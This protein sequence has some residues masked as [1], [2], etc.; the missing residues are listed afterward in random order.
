[1]TNLERNANLTDSTFRWKPDRLHH[2]KEAIGVTVS[3]FE[4]VLRTFAD[5]ASGLDVSKGIV[6]VQIRDEIVEASLEESPGQV[7]V[8]EDGDKVPAAMWITRRIARIPLL[9]DRI[10][11]H[12][13]DEPHYVGPSGQIRDRINAAPDGADKNV[14]EVDAAVLKHLKGT[15]GTTTVHYLTSDAGEGK[16]TVIN[17]MARVQA[18]RFKRKEADWLLLPIRLGGRAF[19]SFDDIVVAE[20]AN[21]LRFQFFY[22][23]AF[24]ELVKMRVIVPAFD[25]FEEMFVERSPGEAISALGNLIQDLESQGSV[26]VAARKAAFEYKNLEA[27]AKLFDAIPDRSVEYA[28]TRLRR[29]NRDQFLDYTRKRGVSD[30]EQVYDKVENRMGSNHPLLTRAVLVKRL[31]DVA[32]EGAA[33][34]LLR[35]LNRDPN[36]Y[37]H[38]FV[39]SIVDREAQEKWIDRSGSPRQPLLSADEH[40]ML[41]AEIAKEMWMTARDALR[42]DYVELVAELFAADRSKRPDIIRQ[43]KGRIT[44]HSLLALQGMLYC[45]DHEDFQRFYLG[46]AIAATYVSSRNPGLDLDD[47]LRKG[48]LTTLAT[49]SAVNAARRKRVDLRLFLET[50]Q[51]LVTRAHPTSYVVENAGA[52]AVRVLEVIGNR[53]PVEL[54]GF[55]FPPDGLKGRQF[56]NVQFKDCQFQSTSLD[57]ARLKGC[58]FV[59]CTMHGLE[60]SKGFRAEGAVIQG[61]SV[62]SVGVGNDGNGIYAPVAVRQAMRN[63]GFRV[64]EPAGGQG[65]PSVEPDSDTQLAERAFRVFLSATHV[66]EDVFKLKCGQQATRFFSHVLPR[67]LAADVL[68]EVAGVRRCRRFKLQVPM[69]AIAAVVPARVETLDELLAS[70][71]S[72]VSY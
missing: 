61:G 47:Y 65:K 58:R 5:D 19:L 6:M 49:D 11:A 54:S 67:M 21:K 46:E 70:I 13:D 24:L 33:D 55:V 15:T 22:Y 69:R 29:W 71:R 4:R 3:E 62:T 59:D 45:F 18:G 17:R 37:F 28:R 43:V 7:Y 72:K 35:R 52:L 64:E 60:W 23:D 42:K 20:L 30:G 16:T 50:L 9:S 10:L 25:G 36:D 66:G 34:D 63:V 56:S 27:Q 41:L 31:V 53:R 1:M 51:W 68:A 2:N 39:E 26:L 40:H 38:G 8:V 12:V 32:E 48:P 57:G 44:Q 14:D